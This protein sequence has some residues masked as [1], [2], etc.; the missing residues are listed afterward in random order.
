MGSQA[1]RVLPPSAGIQYSSGEEPSATCFRC[2]LCCTKYQVLMGLMEA[3]AIADEL[4]LSFEKFVEG[5]IDP[6]WPGER[7]FLLRHQDGHCVFLNRTNEGRESRCSIHRVKPRACLEW[8][9]SL[10]RKECREGLARYWGLTVSVAGNPEGPEANLKEFNAFL[11]S[12][13]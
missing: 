10:F 7:D 5:Y 9:A 2:G 12:L 3:R 4:G 6:A 11:E 13:K 1:D 8:T